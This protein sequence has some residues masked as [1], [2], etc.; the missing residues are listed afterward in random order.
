MDTLNLDF[1]I[2]SIGGMGAN[3]IGKILGEFAALHLNMNASNFSSYGSEK[4]GSPVTAFVRWRT[5]ADGIIENTPVE[6]P[7][8]LVLFHHSLLNSNSCLAGLGTQ[9]TL[10]INSPYT[11]EKIRELYHLKCH[12]VITINCN[13]LIQEHHVRLNMIMLGAI[14]AALTDIINESQP[15]SQSD[16]NLLSAVL[17]LLEK[18]FQEKGKDITQSNQFA[19]KLGYENITISQAEISSHT[20]LFPPSRQISS[21]GYANAPLGGILPS[22][23]N[24]AQNNLSISRSGYLPRYIVEKCINCGLCDTTCPDMVFT[25]REGEYLG[26]RAMINQGPDYQYCK[27]CLRCVET[28]PTQALV[29]VKEEFKSENSIHGADPVITSEGFLSENVM[30]G[31]LNE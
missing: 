19:V 17:N 10:I 2:E 15:K 26:K 24:T 20:I 22:R 31:G 14:L 1:K 18:L 4:T 9:S 25:F 21:I 7:D 23:G 3:L 11:P 29:A 6:N 28:C 30:E 8:I 5:T 16:K 27:G 12:T 13:V